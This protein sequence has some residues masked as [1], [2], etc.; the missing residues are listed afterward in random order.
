MAASSE[1]QSKMDVKKE[2]H[3]EFYNVLVCQNCEQIPKQGPIYSCDSGG[4]ATCNDCFERISK[5]CKCKADIRNRNKALEKMRSTLPLSCKFRKNGCTAILSLESL[6][7]HE[8]DCHWR[9]IFCPELNC[10]S[11]KSNGTKIIYNLLGKHVTE[12]HSSLI[13]NEWRNKSSI[14]ESCFKNSLSITEDSLN[15]KTWLYWT[16]IGHSLNGANFFSEMVLENNRLNIWVY[17]YGS[18]EAAK[19]YN[20]AIKAYGG[21]NEEFIYNGAPRS[22]D[23]S[24]KEVTEGERGLMLSLGQ[25]KRIVTK[26][27]MKYSI[28]ISCPK[29]EAVDEVL[30]I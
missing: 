3:N 5:V 6:L 4:H 10:N 27:K 14:S 23:E 26:G 15:G 11:N 17:Y 1:S 22:L 19:N 18:K 20:C 8:I 2:L 29:E 12:Q 25:A 30:R 13:V 16:P 28:K 9:Q 7:Y 21:D 24:E